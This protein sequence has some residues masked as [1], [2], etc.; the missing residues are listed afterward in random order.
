M[1]I[2]TFNTFLPARLLGTTRLLNFA[3]FAF[4]HVYLAL[5]VYL[6]HK[7]TLL[8]SFWFDAQCLKIQK[9]DKKNCRWLKC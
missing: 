9:E 6:E 5:H 4:L 2:I 3:N 8:Y 7:S 1:L